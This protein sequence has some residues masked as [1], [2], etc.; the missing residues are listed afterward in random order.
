[1][2]ET[3]GQ[4][5][6][7]AREYRN[8]T[9]EKASE[10]TRIRVNYLQALETDDY[11]VMPSAAQGRGFLRNY[12]EFLNVNLEEVIAELQKNPPQEFE[13]SGPLPTADIIPEQP[14]PAD[15][16][17]SRPFWTRYL[18]RKPQAESAPEVQPSEPEPQNQIEVIEAEPPKPRGRK[19]K[20]ETS[21]DQAPRKSGR[22]KSNQEEASVRAVEEIKVT[23]ETLPVEAAQV[24]VQNEAAA[25]N[26]ELG[27][28]ARIVS[29]FKIDVRK[30]RQEEK[31]KEEKV[32][33]PVVEPEPAASAPV[34]SETAEE[35]FISIGREL[36]ARREL[37]S[38]TF[39]EVER[40]TR[41]RAVFLKQMEEGAFDKLPSPVQT[42]GMLSNYAAFLDLDVDAI[43]LRFADALQARH[44]QKYPDKLRSKIPMQT[45]PSMPPLRSFIAGDV[46]F[47]VAMA[48]I[49]IGLGIWGVGRVI[50]SQQSEQASLPTAPSISDVLAGTP[51]PTVLQEITFVPVD[52]LDAVGVGTQEAALEVPTLAAN[53]NVQVLVTAVERSFMRVAVDGETVYDGRVLPGEEFTF[54]AQEQVSILTGNGAALH[55]IYNSRDLGLMGNFGEVISQIYTAGG[56]VT[57]TATIPPTPT[58]TPLVTETPTPTITPTATLPATPTPTP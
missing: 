36:S 43:L 18:A 30:P 26:A 46:I 24:E 1:M 41:V 47:G 51:I 5:L 14:A 57:P 13:I 49:L 45:T 29:R 52:N 53:V 58:E 34:S 8:L 15:E 4:R 23:D 6:K 37:I 44:R 12:A 31:E 3:I 48:V 27:L 22:K 50:S 10:A 20:A 54:E 55:V 42:R 35:I 9:I 28:L 56:L 16:P 32:L 25:G 21:P 7:K 33:E 39:D 11:S 19:K 2:S 38:L 17:G 40:H